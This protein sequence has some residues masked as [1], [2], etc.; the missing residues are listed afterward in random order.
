MRLAVRALVVLTLPMLAFGWL[1][2]ARI[3]PGPPD[4]LRAFPPDPTYA[5]I[6]FLAAAAALVVAG[7]TVLTLADF[8]RG[9]TTPRPIALP[10]VA[11][12]TLA[13]VGQLSISSASLGAVNSLWIWL[14]V[15]LTIAGGFLILLAML[16]LARAL[17]GLW[18]APDLPMW[19]GRRAATV[20]LLLAALAATPVQDGRTN[21]LAFG[22]GSLPTFVPMAEKVRMELTG[23]LH[24]PLW[25][26]HYDESFGL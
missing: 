8:V 13:G 18:S 25:R 3:L 11:L 21:G 5:A 14:E 1:T 23:Q 24:Q 17:V 4:F 26:Y 15:V 22:F 10:V 2:T 9:T 20:L 7:S 12:A 6:L 16:V 19:P